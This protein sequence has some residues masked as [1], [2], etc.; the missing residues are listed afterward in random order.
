MADDRDRT[1]TS[2]DGVEDGPPAMTALEA[3]EPDSGANRTAV[4]P[5]IAGAAHV[6]I[7][8]RV[9][10]GVRQ[11]LLA[12]AVY[13]AL[14]MLGF[15]LPLLQH[16]RLPQVAQSGMDPNFYVW[17]WRWWPYAISHGLNPLYSSQ[18]GAPAGYSLAW[19]TTAPAVALV[20]TPVTAVF[21]PIAAFNVTLLLSAPLSGWAAFLA[22]RRLTGRF[23]P[24]LMAGAV[25]G[26]SSYE[27]SH[28]VAGQPNLT[29]NMLLPLMLYLTLLWRDGKLGRL[30]FVGLMGLAL[31]VEFY[32][33]IETFAETTV[34]WAAGLLIGFVVAGPAARRTVARL[35]G[36]VGIA[37]VVAI[38]LASPYLAYALQ[39]YPAGFTRRSGQYSLNVLDMVVPRPN[40]VFWLT[41]L[42]HY[43]NS[44]R[45]L[46]N[47]AYVGIPLLV[48]VLT[49]AVL[50]WSSRLTRL[51]VILFVLI[52]ALALGPRAVIGTKQ[53]VTLPWARL[54][55]LPIARNAEPLRFI[56]LGYLVLAI[57]MAAWLARPVRSRPL[58][59]LR[60]ILGL[61]AV[62][63]I[64]A[65]LPT[66]SDTNVPP[67]SAQV[68]AIRPTNALP[69][70]ISAGLYRHYLRPGET[71]VVVS[72]RGNAGMLFQADTSFYMRIAGGYIN[73]SLSYPR[74][75][76]PP[77]AL[78]KHPTAARERQ[79]LAYVHQAGIGA[80][81][82]ERSWAAP[83]MAV[84]S[85]MGL[86]S[87]K[88][89]GVIVYRTG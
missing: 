57:I 61:A 40:R 23:W 81:L 87:T 1:R 86:P 70:F 84:F 79:F 88:V 49:L 16:P 30:A 22:A 25:Y 39:H 67:A 82:V 19:A 63:A 27:V 20:L 15:A 28:T 85:Q 56:L 62:A 68:A 26:F 46:S 6:P 18:I 29:V 38:V 74:G 64:L 43:A 50:T 60:W 13:L 71:V 8:A 76:P 75:L 31:A 55:A 78:L 44:L 34:I 53:L 51:L 48:I 21:G 89:G 45:G 52:V 73:Q 83:W 35:A 14:F 42:T 10:S 72:D 4:V 5:R 24:A 59:V 41:S 9:P 33:F 11:G 65:D 12:L 80:I 58:L 7:Y 77:V 66:V 36:L 2:A 3:D 17:S 37:Y 32:I 47:E 54:W 69:T